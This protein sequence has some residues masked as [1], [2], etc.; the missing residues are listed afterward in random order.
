MVSGRRSSVVDV[1][2]TKPQTLAT[3]LDV[4]RRHIGGLSALLVLRMR[5]SSELRVSFQTAL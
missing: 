4:L 5:A 2:S 3:R 1:L